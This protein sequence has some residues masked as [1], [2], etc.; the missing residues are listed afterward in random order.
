MAATMPAILVKNSNSI[1]RVVSLICSSTAQ[2]AD[3]NVGIGTLK[4]KTT[5]TND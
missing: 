5:D 2:T 4:C 1:R 3:D